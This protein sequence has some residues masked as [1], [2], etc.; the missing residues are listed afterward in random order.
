MEFEKDVLNPWI[1]RVKMV[2][3]DPQQMALQ[4]VNRETAEIREIELDVDTINVIIS[5]YKK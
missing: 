1:I 3:V 5:K 2:R 4:I